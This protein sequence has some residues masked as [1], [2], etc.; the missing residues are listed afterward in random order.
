MKKH[1]G[2]LFCDNKTKDILNMLL[3]EC[4]KYQVKIQINQT[5]TAIKHQNNN[6]FILE[7]TD[8]KIQC[9]SLV[10]ATGGLSIPTMGASPFGYKIAEQFGLKV[11]PTSAGLVPFTLHVA[12]KEKYAPLSGVAVESIVSNHRASFSEA[13][14][15]THRGLSGP[16]ALQLSSYWQPGEAI[17]INLLPN[18]NLQD[19]LKAAKQTHPNMML[20]NYLT[21]QFPSRLIDIFIEEKLATTTLQALSHKNINLIADQLHQWQLK[22]N[23][24]EG[25]RTAEVTLGGI[26]TT[27]LSSKTMATNTIPNLYFIGEVLDITGWLGGYNFQW[28]WSSGWA[29]GQVV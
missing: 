2:Q 29:A 4:D 24:T 23:A 6:L 14:L 15:F 26:D 3:A 17:T 21:K 5:V 22:P 20:K 13:I 10:I 8:T 25:Y 9:Q 11:W 27:T 1:W 12:D 19:Q 7:L 16:A 28:A 18:E